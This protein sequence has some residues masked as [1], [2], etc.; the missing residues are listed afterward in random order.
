MK[1]GRT[2]GLG[3]KNQAKE[4]EI[5]EKEYKRWIMS[6]D[7]STTD[8]DQR[9]WFMDQRSEVIKKWRNRKK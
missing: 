9:E 1:V 6:M 4:T 5:E 8:D 3:S 2:Q 7:P